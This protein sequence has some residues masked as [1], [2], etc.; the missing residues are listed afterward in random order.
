MAKSHAKLSIAILS[1]ALVL[2]FLLCACDF[3][4][5]SASTPSASTFVCIDI[6]PSIEMV[7]DQNNRVMSV[8]GANE[9]AQLLLWQ[10]DGIVGVDVDLAIKRIIAIAKEMGY[11]GND[12]QIVN[13]SV[14]TALDGARDKI[15]GAIESGIS[16]VAG[17]L[18]AVIDDIASLSLSK[19][20]EKLKEASQKYSSLTESKYRLIKRAMQSDES[21]SLDEAMSLS[22]DKLIAK[23]K[24]AQSQSANKL[25]DDY[26]SVVG[27]AQFEFENA[28]VALLDAQYVK[29]FLSK[30]LNNGFLSGGL[31]NDHDNLKQRLIAAIRYSANH[32]AYIALD[33]YKT[34]LEGYVSN[35]QI[36]SDKF[37]DILD[38]FDG[39]IDAQAL[40][41]FKSKHQDGTLFD[42]D[43]LLNFVNTQY[44]N[45]QKDARDEIE[46]AFDQALTLLEG[47]MYV[48]GDNLARVQQAM[49]SIFENAPALLL[50]YMNGA[51]NTLAELFNESV[52][53][54]DYTSL[55]NVE[56]AL[57]IY[58]QRMQAAYDDMCL[59]EHDLQQI[60]QMQALQEQ[61]IASLQ[62]IF[63]S[64]V[65]S[66]KERT[67]DALSSLKNEKKNRHK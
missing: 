22:Q 37:D 56:Q 6:N 58:E 61:S 67:E 30:I 45:A 34:L 36:E 35:P 13:V 10:E 55:A 21:L 44:R 1:I 23:V 25:G 9:D 39:V 46:E 33:Y 18:K 29:Y 60:E 17:N 8:Q 65:M 38:E 27:E 42:K 64:A 49:A 15:V 41:Q 51:L 40:E 57:S 3:P 47:A 4:S 43:E 48:D 53:S 62:E 2:C 52:L 59:D 26:T 11:V 50:S 12:E 16:S 28:R 19:E 32:Q 14:E 5:F 24:D 31:G 54:V 66:A 63:N 20:L 7:L